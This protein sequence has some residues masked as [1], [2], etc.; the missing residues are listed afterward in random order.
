M[1]QLH[2]WTSGAVELLQKRFV[3]GNEN[4]RRD[5]D[6]AKQPEDPLLREDL[7]MHRQHLVM[8]SSFEACLTLRDKTSKYF[9]ICGKALNFTPVRQRFFV[10]FSYIICILFSTQYFL[11][12]GYYI[13]NF[14][15]SAL[16]I[17]IVSFSIK[18]MLLPVS[19]CWRCYAADIYGSIQKICNFTNQRNDISLLER[20]LVN[21]FSS[22][23]LQNSKQNHLLGETNCRNPLK[24]RCTLEQHCRRS[25]QKVL[26]SSSRQGRTSFQ[27]FSN[28]AERKILKTT[29]TSYRL[30]LVVFIVLNFINPSLALPQ[31]QS[32]DSLESSRR[33]NFFVAS[34]G[35]ETMDSSGSAAAMDMCDEATCQENYHCVPL[36]SGY[37]CQCN[38][39]YTEQNGHCEL[40]L[41]KSCSKQDND[42]FCLH[43]GICV[44]TLTVGT[45]YARSCRCDPESGYTGTKCEQINSY[46]LSSAMQRFDSKDVQNAT[47]LVLVI[48]LAT[49]VVLSVVGR[50]RCYLRDKALEMQMV[51]ALNKEYDDLTQQLNDC[52]GSG[53]LGHVLAEP[54]ESRS[55]SSSYVFRN[56]PQ[57]S[58]MLHHYSYANTS[59]L[60][61]QPRQMEKSASSIRDALSEMKLQETE[62]WLVTMDETWLLRN[63]EDD[64]VKFLK[65]MT[66]VCWLASNIN[67]IIQ[68]IKR[69]LWRT[70]C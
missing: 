68:S 70:Q 18:S 31:L 35:I 1:Q 43:G 51:A 66:N 36:R 11:F 13:T 5:S 22:V 2:L 65:N 59:S 32:S 60:F 62:T 25:Q 27:L 3:F 56:S 4:G 67:L 40:A 9:E 45:H 63:A 58:S 61:P 44:M 7:S 69:S 38:D 33:G 28:S 42:S 6:A 14:C 21:R 49:L 8:T 57:T 10:F 48:F 24:L 23:A 39:G 29:E 64:V 46:R 55:L 30:L 12:H 15:F 34:S 37:K 17:F 50:L 26:P 47:A 54:N 52:G 19:K 53:S 16:E 20:F 41:E